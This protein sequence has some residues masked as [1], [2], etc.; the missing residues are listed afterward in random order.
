MNDRSRGQSRSQ[1]AG[2][3]SIRALGK[4]LATVS[5]ACALASPASAEPGID[6][7][8]IRIGGVMDLKGDSRGLGL[9]MKAGIEAA[10]KGVSVNGHTLEFV[11][12]NDNYSPK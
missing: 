2:V 3:E 11:A 4:L 5:L 12:L 9:G 1:I 10:F 8:V 7:N 6:G